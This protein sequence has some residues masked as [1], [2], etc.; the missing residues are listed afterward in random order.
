MD[1]DSKNEAR[2]EIGSE[3]DVNGLMTNYRAVTISRGSGGWGGPISVL[4]DGQKKYVVSVTGGGI[5]PV[6]KHIAELTGAEPI[7][8]FSN[9]IEAAEMACV[10]IDCGG[11]ARCGVYPKMGV[12]TVNVIPTSPSGP[13]MRFILETNFVSGVSESDIML[14]EANAKPDES[15]ASPVM[16]AAQLDPEPIPEPN[17]QQ[18]PSFGSP[19]SGLA[20]RAGRRIAWIMNLFVQSGR[21]T[22]ETVLKNVLPFMA[23]VSMLTGVF[24]YTGFGEFVGRTL[25]PLTGNIGGLLVL[26]AIL[27][28]PILSPLLGPGSVLAQVAGV[29]IGVEIGLGHFP[30]QLALPALFAI[31]PQAGCDFAPVGLTLGEAKP[32]TV[33]VGVPAILLSRQITGPIS[34]LIAYVFSIGL[35]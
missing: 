24:L 17:A 19:N 16:Q 11:T 29:L 34:V 15:D 10:V 5:H 7:D 12:Q 8:G 3:G 6:A 1:H 23:F 30:P 9:S 14:S 22:I 28:M 25:S 35:Y 31:T 13:L 21:D 18:E 4:P 2:D 20:D 27:A 33:R 26:S 32:E